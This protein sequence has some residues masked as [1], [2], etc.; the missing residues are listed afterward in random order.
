MTD[1]LNKGDINEA[2]AISEDIKS[3]LEKINHHG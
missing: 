2:K 3:N 1:E